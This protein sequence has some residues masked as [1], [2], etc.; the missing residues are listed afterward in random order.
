M[1]A[2]ILSEWGRHL[3]I[4]QGKSVRR[5]HAPKV[6]ALSTCHIPPTP[7][8]TELSKVRPPA[9]RNVGQISLWLGEYNGLSS[10]EWY[11]RTTPAPTYL[12]PRQK[13]SQETCSVSPSSAQHFVPHAGPNAAGQATGSE[14]ADQVIQQVGGG[15]LAVHLRMVSPLSEAI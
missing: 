2:A 15:V 10:Q 11:S 13:P 12:I 3:F 9:A 7:L 1:V 4:F 14:R 8:G 5:R 6:L